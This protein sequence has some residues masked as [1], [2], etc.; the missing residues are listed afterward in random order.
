[1]ADD[2]VERVLPGLTLD[3]H[4]VAR[5]PAAQPAAVARSSGD[6]LAVGWDDSVF[7]ARSG[8]VTRRLTVIPHARTQS[9][10]LTQGP[11]ERSLDLASVHV[12]STPGP[13][14]SH[15]PAPGRVV[16]ADVADEQAAGAERAAVRRTGRSGGPRGLTG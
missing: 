15:R 14:K 3:G 5:G 8:R 2:I 9:V 6:S 12:D 4:G 16:G 10:R 11:W 7:A 1:M 13:V